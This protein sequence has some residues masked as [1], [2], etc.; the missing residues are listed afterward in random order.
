MIKKLRLREFVQKPKDN[1][2]IKSLCRILG[3]NFNNLEYIENNS[4]FSNH[5]TYILN[6]T[7][8]TAGDCND[9]I[10]SNK[11]IFRLIDNHR[12]KTGDY[13][14]MYDSSFGLIYID[15]DNNKS[16]RSKII[17]VPSD[18]V[19]EMLEQVEDDNLK[20]SNGYSDNNFTEEEYF[21]HI[22]D[23]KRHLEKFLQAFDSM[24]E[25][26]F[27]INDY[28][29]YH[30]ILAAEDESELIGRSALLGSV[31]DLT[32]LYNYYSNK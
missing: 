27:T 23:A 15:Y 30:S 32:K 28:G 4:E 13:I 16:G 8:N 18:N 10:R 25:K 3:I 5:N 22:K 24:A 26:E 7:G 12:K 2:D 21:D 14:K 17:M 20:E 11:K 1:A 6:T 9:K 29:D 19:Y 31:R